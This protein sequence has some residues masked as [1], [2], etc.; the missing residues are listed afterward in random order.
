MAAVS[1]VGVDALGKTYANG[2]EALKRVSF[3]VGSGEIFGLLGPND[4]GKSTT[5]GV[6][7]TTVRPTAGRALVAENDVVG[8]PM[9]VRGAIGVTFQDSV[10]DTD[11]SGLQNLRLHARMFGIPRSMPSLVSRNCSR[12][13][14]SPPE[15]GTASART[16]EACAEARDRQ[17]PS[18]AAARPA[19]RRAHRGTGSDGAT[20]DLEPHQAVSSTRERHHPPQHP[21]PRGGRGRVRS[22]RDHQRRKTRRP[23]HSRAVGGVARASGY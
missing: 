9:A 12:R 23:R 17:S 19:A 14:A 15:P 18:R 6:L 8:D 7:T 13:W 16:A 21:L 10:L 2:V 11:F 22:S 1:P 5:I 20:R 3:T 4:A